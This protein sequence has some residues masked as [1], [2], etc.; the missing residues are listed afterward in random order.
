MVNSSTHGGVAFDCVAQEVRHVRETLGTDGALLCNSGAT[1]FK[2][3]LQWLWRYETFEYRFSHTTFQI[4]KPVYAGFR[5]M[6]CDL[7]MKSAAA[8]TM[9]T[10]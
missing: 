10:G 7:P 2:L 6:R 4:W 3:N 9:T 5:C 8:A 1:K